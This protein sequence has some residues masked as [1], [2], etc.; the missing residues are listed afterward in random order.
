MEYT[1]IKTLLER[2]ISSFR[3]VPRG[4]PVLKPRKAG[5][6]ELQRWGQLVEA[7]QAAQARL[8]AL[9]PQLHSHKFPARSMKYS[10]KDEID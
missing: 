9:K 10:W 1:P 3:G 7:V 8:P 4:V 5:L 2:A 6:E